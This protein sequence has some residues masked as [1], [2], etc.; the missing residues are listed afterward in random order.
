MI[1]KFFGGET[2]SKWS[3]VEKETLIAFSRDEQIVL[4]AYRQCVCAEDR[5]MASRV[6]K[7]DV[8]SDVAM[9]SISKL[10]ELGFV[11]KIDE[12][13]PYQNLQDPLRRITGLGMQALREIGKD[14]R[15]YERDVTIRML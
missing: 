2:G 1:R 10:E 12:S 7:L 15:S 11:K 8:S 5:S 3:S 4:R 13:H 6:E 9:A 14:P